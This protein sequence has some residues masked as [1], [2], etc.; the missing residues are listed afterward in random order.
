MTCPGSPRP[1]G[2]GR[3][4]SPNCHLLSFLSPNADQGRGNALCA[5]WRKDSCAL[6]KQTG[7]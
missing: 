2:G 1:R 3:R 5:V 4:P 6:Y 7:I